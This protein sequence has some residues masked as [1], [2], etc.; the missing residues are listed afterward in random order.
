MGSTRTRCRRPGRPTSTRTRGFPAAAGV[1]G[2]KGNEQDADGV[3]NNNNGLVD[4]GFIRLTVTPR[5]GSARSEILA[6]DV[7]RAS[8]PDP[9]NPTS[10]LAPINLSDPLSILP[11]GGGTKN[12]GFVITRGAGSADDTL[13]I[14]ITTAG[15]LEDKTI[16]TRQVVETV[17]LRN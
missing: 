5:T 9:A 6:K 12:H 11:N 2:Y 17:L 13:T 15:R 7:L 8:M 16:Y 14:V 10:W 1:A 4:E 3:D